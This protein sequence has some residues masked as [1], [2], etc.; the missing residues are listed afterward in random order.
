M[1]I[2]HTKSFTLFS[3]PFLDTQLQCYKTIITLNTIPAG[4]LSKFTTRI[5][6]NRLSEF[7]TPGPCCPNKKCEFTLQSF[8]GNGPM[9]IEELPDLFSFL[10]SNNYDINTQLTKI[11]KKEETGGKNTIAF[12][13]FQL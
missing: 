6:M 5:R 2:S 4:P 3:Q 13:T 9:N 11:L 7:K 8:Y 1:N 12:V 10:T